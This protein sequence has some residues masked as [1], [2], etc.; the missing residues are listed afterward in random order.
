MK[1]LFIVA[2]VFLFGSAGVFA[3]T[4]R[5]KTDTTKHQVYTC[6]MHPEVVSD[7]PGKCP[8]CGMTLVLSKK[9]QAK[10]YTCPMHPEVV[11]DKPGRCPK[12]GMNLVE[13]KSGKPMDS[14]LSK[15]PI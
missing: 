7:K 3:Q 8:K 12:C 9:T 14:S 1:T 6:P 4:S 2:I 11:S 13:K 15:K 5:A 10:I